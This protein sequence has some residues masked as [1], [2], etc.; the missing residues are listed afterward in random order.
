MR[1]ANDYG[2][3]EPNTQTT[4]QFNFGPMVWGKLYKKGS[5]DKKDELPAWS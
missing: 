2:K 5:N 4:N 3:N 1:S